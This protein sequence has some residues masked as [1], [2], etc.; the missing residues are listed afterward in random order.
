ME[1]EHALQPA[2]PEHRLTLNTE[3]LDEIVAFAR[4][5]ADSAIITSRAIARLVEIADTLEDPTNNPAFV[6]AWNEVVEI[7]SVA[8]T[9]NHV[10]G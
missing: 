8:K 2:T 6:E 10:M 5:Y 1:Q 9:I 7:N 3:D 4:Q